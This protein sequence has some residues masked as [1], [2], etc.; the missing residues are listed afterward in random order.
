MTIDYEI[1]AVYGATKKAI[2]A[3]QKDLDILFEEGYIEETE[4]MEI[5]VKHNI[6]ILYEFTESSGYSEV[7]LINNKGD[8]VDG[9][10][11]SIE[12]VKDMQQQHENDT[13]LSSFH[14]QDQD[15][16]LQHIER[17]NITMKAFFDE[18]LDEF[19]LDQYEDKKDILSA[20][21]KD[22]YIK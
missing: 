18:F 22:Y 12:I 7:L 5:A 2:S 6:V 8:H 11:F 19:L 17:H 1:I 21:I 15:K 10:M 14:K 3:A 4:V 9:S 16:I 13:N 20:K